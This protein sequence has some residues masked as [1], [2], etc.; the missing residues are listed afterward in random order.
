[1]KI[2]KFEKPVKKGNKKVNPKVKE[3]RLR[4]LMKLDSFLVMGEI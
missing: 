2:L 4:K 1:M 3:A